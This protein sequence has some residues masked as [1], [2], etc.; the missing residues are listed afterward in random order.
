MTINLKEAGESKTK[1]EIINH[2][3]L[4]PGDTL[5]EPQFAA[6]AVLPSGVIFFN[7]PLPSYFLLLADNPLSHDPIVPQSGISSSC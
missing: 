4:N 2:W 3:E 7:N 6:P 5:S 1:G